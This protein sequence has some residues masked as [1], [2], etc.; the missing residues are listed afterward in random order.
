MIDTTLKYG[1]LGFARS[2]QA[3]ADRL[4]VAGAQYLISDQSSADKFALELRSRYNCEFGSHSEEFLKSDLIIVSPGVPYRAPIILKAQSLGIEVISEIEFG[5]RIKHPKSKI[6]AVTGSNGKSTT[7]SLIHHILK[8]NG[9]HSILAG[10]I[11]DAFTG[12]PIDKEGIDFIVLEISSFQL[13]LIRD[14]KPDVAAI[15]NITPDHLNRY[16][17]FEHYG[18]TKFKLLSNLDAGNTVVLNKDDTFIQNKLNEVKGDIKQFSMLNIADAFFKDSKV[19]SEL[20]EINSNDISIKGP[21]NIANSMAAILC[22]EKYL[23]LDEIKIGLEDFK[24][25]EHRLEY[26]DTVNSV[27]FYNDSKATNTDSVKFALQSFNSPIR[28]ILGGSDKGEDF[29]ILSPYLKD[30]CAHLYLIGETKDKMKKSFSD[31]TNKSEYETLNDAVTS[32]YKHSQPGDIVLLSP[33]CA[34]YDM[35]KNYEHRGNS[36]KEIVQEIKNETE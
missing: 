29:S 25:L 20:G 17:N 18:D 3:V 1:I 13:E 36:F 24:S 26:V 35:F 15:L 21:H 5:Y 14:F 19:I 16:D 6:I 32:A 31:F 22:L 28:I 11:G 27:K 9:Y 33:A 4:K 2:G 7:V 23:T 8:K 12:Y 30:S 34:S 10:N